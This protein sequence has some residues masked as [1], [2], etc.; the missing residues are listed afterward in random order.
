[1][2][3]QLEGSCL[4]GPLVTPPFLCTAQ[5]NLTSLPKNDVRFEREMLAGYKDSMGQNFLGILIVC[6]GV[7]VNGDVMCNLSA[8]IRQ[9][10][11]D[12]A[13]SITAQQT[14]LDSLAPVVH[15]KSCPRFSFD[16]AG[17]CACSG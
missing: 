3:G 12:T 6:A 7:Y 4:L 11:E 8:T 1:M 2:S 17:R 14:A 5:K 16:K 15:G 13:K 9:M 10:A